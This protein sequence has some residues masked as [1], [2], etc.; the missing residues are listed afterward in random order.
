MIT[1]DS[2]TAE[3]LAALREA[4]AEGYDE[5]VKDNANVLESAR[6]VQNKPTLRRVR[7]H[8]G[9][10]DGCALLSGGLTFDPLPVAPTEPLPVVALYTPYDA[11]MH[12][13]RFWMPSLEWKIRGQKR[14]HS[15]ERLVIEH[16]LPEH[17]AAVDRP[18]R[19]IVYSLRAALLNADKA[20]AGSYQRNIGHRA[21][22]T[23]GDFKRRGAR[24]NDR[25]GDRQYAEDGEFAIN[26]M[27]ALDESD[28]E[29]GK[30]A[31]LRARL[32]KPKA[33]KVPM[34]SRDPQARRLET[35][36]KMRW[37]TQDEVAQIREGVLEP[38][39][40]E[41]WGSPEV[42]RKN[43][44]WIAAIKARSK[45]QTK[46]LLT[47]LTGSG[48]ARTRKSGWSNAVAQISSEA[49]SAE[50]S[51]IS[52]EIDELGRPTPYG[53]SQ[54]F[55]AYG[56]PDRSAIDKVLRKSLNL[57]ERFALALREQRHT[58]A[59]IM[60]HQRGLTPDERFFWIDYAQ[61]RGY[62]RPT[63]QQP[64]TRITNLDRKLGQIIEQLRQRPAPRPV[65]GEWTPREWFIQLPPPV[66]T[67]RS[68]G[69]SACEEHERRIEQRPQLLGDDWFWSFQPPR[70]VE[71]RYVWKWK[72]RSIVSKIKRRRNLTYAAPRATGFLE[73]LPIQRH[74]PEDLRDFEIRAVAP[75]SGTHMRFV[76]RHVAGTTGVFCRD[77]AV[78]LLGRDPLGLIPQLD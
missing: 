38:R 65:C 73:L 17:D 20:A 77:H 25:T 19:H 28:L 67:A 13:A 54:K 64:S 57:S 52:G 3:E 43:A 51:H 35:N 50:R 61:Q 12:H 2:L 47:G 48:R 15:K 23:E 31:K 27:M 66:W 42:A 10:R 5:A 53:L 78:R 63:F 6:S 7:V 58:N 70:P 9:R 60:R 24:L 14:P 18:E 68:T 1:I 21:D 59:E 33:K 56:K 16:M 41:M 46:E 34:A 45:T 4:T 37:D 40:D 39:I 30:L 71:S 29:P 55:V 74:L 44:Q 22:T 72:T 69:L 36:F 32:E 75:D 26:E 76:L 8:P 11:E 49:S 62:G